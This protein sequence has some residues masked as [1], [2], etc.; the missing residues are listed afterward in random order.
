MYPIFFLIYLIFKKKIIKYLD[1]RIEQNLQIQSLK[2]A[3]RFHLPN[4]TRMCY[5]KSPRSN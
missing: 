3:S 1:K 4:S 5:T 2:N